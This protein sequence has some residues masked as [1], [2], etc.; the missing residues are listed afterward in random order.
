MEVLD[1]ELMSREFVFGRIIPYF[2]EHG[3]PLSKAWSGWESRV[4]T[5]LPEAPILEAANKM[6]ENRLSGL[7]VLDASGRL[8]GSTE[9]R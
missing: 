4:I 8:V 5:V 7:P 2:V 9:R 1:D 6:L 3:V